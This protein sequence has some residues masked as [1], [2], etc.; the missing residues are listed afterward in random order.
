MPCLK[1]SCYF[2][3][4]FPDYTGALCVSLTVHC[5]DLSSF[6]RL[7][8]SKCGFNGNISVVKG[9]VVLT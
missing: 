5:V 9:A 2:F 6:L 3:V 4:G 1:K 8:S 7:T